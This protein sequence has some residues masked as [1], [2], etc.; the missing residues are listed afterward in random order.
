MS[1]PQRTYQRIAEGIEE[2]IRSE[3]FKVGDRLP[4]ERDLS[5]RFEVSRTTVRE[6]LLALEA[7]DLIEIRDRSGAYIL[8][9]STRLLAGLR[10]FEHAPGPHEVLQLRRLIEGQASFL[11]AL[12]AAPAVIRE[13]VEAADANEAIEPDDTDEFHEATRLFHLSIVNAAGNL[14]FIELFNFLWA[15]K[16]GQLWER[17]YQRTKSR[18]NRLIVLQHNREVTNAIAGRRPDAA[19]TAMEHHFDWMVERFLGWP[20]Q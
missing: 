12:N 17:W 13:I 20:D 2:M 18:Q 11:A 16:S 1:T 5:V 19:R 3:G 9:K 15:Q 7:A 6:A 10:K 4:P 8:D 14:L